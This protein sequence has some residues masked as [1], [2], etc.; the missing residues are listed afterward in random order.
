MIQ[1]NADAGISHKCNLCSDITSFGEAPV[2]AQVCMSDAISYGEVEVLKMEAEGK[3]RTI[4]EEL[5]KES[6]LY[7]K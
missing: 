4:I 5:S 2:C 7:V 1:F 6:H 3:G